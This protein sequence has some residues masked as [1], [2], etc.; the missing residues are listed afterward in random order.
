M[1]KGC[2]DQ[3][4][5]WL[6]MGMWGILPVYRQDGGNGSE[7][8]F[9]DREPLR[10]KRG[11][12]AL[13]KGLAELYQKDMRLLRSQA[14]EITGQRTMNPLPVDPHIILIPFKTR[15]PIGRDDG[16][17]GYIFLS[18]IADACREGNGTRI[19]LKDGRRIPVLES[20]PTARRHI[21]QGRQLQSRMVF[22]GNAMEGRMAALNSLREE[23]DRPATRGDIALLIGRISYLLGQLKE[24]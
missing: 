24:K 15:K 16:A 1:R 9:S 6:D 21:R 22:Q 23:C 7:I 5:E 3:C 19:V 8:L 20:F 17:V 10:D 14:R 2:R 11:V 12:R 18:G 13:V 4:R